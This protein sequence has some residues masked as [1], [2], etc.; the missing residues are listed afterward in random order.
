M[1]SVSKFFFNE[2]IYRV[3]FKRIMRNRQLR[4]SLVEKF[5]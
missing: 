2:I 1:K 3:N 5:E 4:P